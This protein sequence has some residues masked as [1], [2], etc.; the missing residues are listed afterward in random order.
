MA[1]PMNVATMPKTASFQMRINPE[2]KTAGGRDFCPLRPDADRCRQHLF[3]AVAQYRRSA[4]FGHTKQP[5][6]ATRTGGRAADGRTQ[7]WGKIRCKAKA[8]GSARMKCWQNLR[9]RHETSLHTGCP[10]RPARYAGLYCPT[11][12]KNQ[13]AAQRF[14]DRIVKSCARLKD[15]PRMGA[16]LSEKTGRDTDLRYLVC[17]DQ[18]AFLPCGGRQPNGLG[19]PYFGWANRLY[20][21]NF[22]G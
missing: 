12:L 8:T 3:A 6:G 15:Q 9:G 14:T 2:V 10:R 17:G 11:R 20:A 13:T 19:H 5:A 7:A 1:E 16:A 18:I 22:Q 21:R 4:V